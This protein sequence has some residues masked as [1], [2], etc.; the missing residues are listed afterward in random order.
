[1][2]EFQTWQRP[3]FWI[4]PMD[5]LLRILYLLNVRSLLLLSSWSEITVSYQRA[6]ADL[7]LSIMVGSLS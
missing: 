1:M 2:S 6:S 4:F 3:I 7:A 5:I